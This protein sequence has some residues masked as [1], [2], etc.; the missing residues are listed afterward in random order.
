MLIDGKRTSLMDEYCQSHQKSPTITFQGNT[1]ATS[2]YVLWL[3]EK[4]KQLKSQIEAA[5]HELEPY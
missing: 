2:A 3:E 5:Q 4:V 1:W